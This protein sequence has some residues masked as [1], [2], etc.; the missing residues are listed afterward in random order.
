MKTMA[1]PLAQP[2]RLTISWT[3][4]LMSGVF[5]AASR[6]PSVLKLGTAQDTDAVVLVRALMSLVV[7]E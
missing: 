6:S 5:W 1:L 4:V 3:T 7:V 2:A